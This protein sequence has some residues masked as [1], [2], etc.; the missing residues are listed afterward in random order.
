MTPAEVILLVGSPGSGKSW[1]SSQLKDKFLVLEHDDFHQ[2]EHYIAALASAARQAKRK[3]LGNT[4]FGLTDLTQGLAGIGVKVIPVFI[5]EPD[6]VL[7]ARYMQREKK[8]IPK[9]H[10]TRQETYRSRAKE[11]GS[12][13][14]TSAEVLKHLKGMVSH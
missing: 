8:S 1:V 13:I 5:V 11:L 12:F 10:I 2:K 6:I 9:G 4:P 3:I 14:G 7:S